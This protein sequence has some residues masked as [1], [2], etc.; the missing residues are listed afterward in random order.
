VA[1]LPDE[2]WSARPNPAVTGAAQTNR[3]RVLLLSGDPMHPVCRSPSCCAD[4]SGHRTARAS[5]MRT[6]VTSMNRTGRAGPSTRRRRRC[7]GRRLAT[8]A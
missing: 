8:A 7:Q 1:I 4:A 3:L 6:P 5:P 2:Q